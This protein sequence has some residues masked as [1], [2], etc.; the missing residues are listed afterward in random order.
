MQNKDIQLVII[1]RT[2]ATDY[3]HAVYEKSAEMYQ[4]KRTIL[5][6]HIEYPNS[7]ENH[8]DQKE[9]FII[10]GSKFSLVDELLKEG[11]PT[12]ESISGN[13]DL[14]P[15]DTQA[16]KAVNNTALTL[17]NIEAIKFKDVDYQF[18]LRLSE[19]MGYAVVMVTIL[20]NHDEELEVVTE[21]SANIN[22]PSGKL[23]DGNFPGSP[24]AKIKASELKL[25]LNI[26]RYP[27]DHDDVI[28]LQKIKVSALKAGYIEANQEIEN[29][30]KK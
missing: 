8:K 19:S 23:L 15:I 22:S 26:L 24:S 28:F 4:E 27:W 17:I 10:S 20:L 9:Y 1:D 18:H 2:S 12:S 6:L 16:I 21:E 11:C 3:M 7:S 30:L 14:V 29:D 25:K 5:R 13:D